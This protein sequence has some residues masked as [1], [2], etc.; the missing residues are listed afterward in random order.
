[1]LSSSQQDNCR[2][3]RN[4]LGAKTCNIR[5][6]CNMKNLLLMI[7]AQPLLLMTFCVQQVDTEVDIAAIAEAGER[8]ITALEE[9]DVEVIMAGLSDDHITMA[10]N[11]SAFY[12]TMVDELNLLRS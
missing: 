5:K 2:F 7:I 11:T 1:M 12:D 3:L 10:P 8:L 9:D 4:I 6:E